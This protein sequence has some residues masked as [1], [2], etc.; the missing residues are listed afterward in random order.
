[1]NDTVKLTLGIVGGFFALILLLLFEGGGMFGMGPMMGGVGFDSG[2]GQMMGGFGSWWILVPILFWG[3]LL[4]LI[5]WVVARIFPKGQSG[6]DEP[7]RDN[8]EEVLRE[9]L[10]RGEV[11]AEGYE[12][13]L[14]VL[15]GNNQRSKES[16]LN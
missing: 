11:D 1:M 4:A 15:R 13:S 12:R 6:S 3:G 5:S 9:R 8:A 10:A 7:R 2:P 16:N 14:Q